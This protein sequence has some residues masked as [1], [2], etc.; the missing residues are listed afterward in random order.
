MVMVFAVLLLYARL[1]T[2]R[3]G[4]E[5]LHYLGTGAASHSIPTGT[6]TNVLTS[7]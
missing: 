1:R 4:T 5:M 2:E 7:V 6:Y 3:T